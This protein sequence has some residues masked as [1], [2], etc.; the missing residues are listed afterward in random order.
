MTTTITAAQRE[1]AERYAEIA[2]SN[3]LDAEVTENDLG[4]V[5]V[6]VR[7]PGNSG[8]F[9]QIIVMASR[10]RRTRVGAYEHVS[11]FTR[12]ATMKRVPVRGIGVSIRCMSL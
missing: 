4:Q 6:I 10:G 7:R 3:H 9:L 2:R 12:P 8:R 5:Q 11:Y 1:R